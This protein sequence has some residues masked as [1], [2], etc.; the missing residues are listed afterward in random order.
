MTADGLPA[1]DGRA[2]PVDHHGGQVRFGI[3]NAVQAMRELCECLLDDVLSRL[4][5]AE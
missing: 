2:A 1:P 3:V 5:V 4:D